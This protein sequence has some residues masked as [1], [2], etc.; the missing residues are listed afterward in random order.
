MTHRSIF[1]T[2]RTLV[3]SLTLLAL[4]GALAASSQEDDS[5]LFG[6]IIDVRVINL[7]AVVTDKKGNRVHGLT[8]DDFRLLVDGVEV[9]VD[10]FSEVL[11]GVAAPA[12][13]DPS[14]ISSLPALAAGEPVGTSYLIFIDDFFTIG[15]QRDLVLENLR[16]EVGRLGPADRM[17]IVAF[18]GKRL[19]LLSSWSQSPSEL[20][21][22]LDAAM[23]RPAFGPFRNSERRRLGLTTLRSAYTSYWD[24][25]AEAEALVSALQSFA[26]PPGRKVLLALAGAWPTGFVDADPFEEGR[27]DEASRSDLAT[28][29]FSRSSFSAVSYSTD[30]D[31]DVLSIVSETANLLG[32][33]IYPLDVPGLR[34]SF[35]DASLARPRE[36]GSTTGLADLERRGTLGYVAAQTGGRPLFA[37]NRLRALETVQGDVGSYYW[38]GFQADRRGTDKGHKIR[39]ETTRPGLKIRH[40]RGYLDLSRRAEAAMKTQS[41]LLLG[42]IEGLAAPSGLTAVASAGRKAGRGKME[43]SVEI[44]VPLEDVTVLP[45]AEGWATE[46][47]LLIAVQDESGAQ[48]DIPALPLRLTVDKEPGP[49][50]YARYS[51]TLK[52]RRQAHDVVVSIHDPATGRVLMRAL[53]ISP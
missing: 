29:P 45:T 35:A 21:R 24:L 15:A 37:S 34:S 25:A 9:P 39:L 13:I 20:E 5:G 8:A 46:V 50:S 18:D 30:T 12:G 10:Y 40:R 38:L 51:T 48:A 3:L 17:A 27:P 53:E 49:E 2:A 47:E 33:T 14:A 16:E 31:L 42:S 26:Q 28:D 52:L 1:G 41:A 43:V 22:A 11:G 4:F 44:G 6:E 32:Y 23:E 7:E 19:D 36:P